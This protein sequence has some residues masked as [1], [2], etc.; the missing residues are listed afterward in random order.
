MT[1]LVWIC[2]HPYKATHFENRKSILHFIAL[3]V[4]H[5]DSSQWSHQSSHH[6]LHRLSHNRASHNRAPERTH[7]SPS[8]QR[9][10]F[11][12]TQP[13]ELWDLLCQSLS[14]RPSV[15]L[16]SHALTVQG[17]EICSA[18]HDGGTSLVSGDQIC[19][20]EFRAC[21]KKDCDKQ[22]NAIATIWKIG[23][24]ISETC[25]IGRRLLLFRHR[26][27][28]SAFHWYRIRSWTTLNDF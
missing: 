23:P 4:L 21:G 1:I 5:T 10:T 20:A 13:S 9:S 15:T 6:C 22:R 2:V 25:K 26:K 17:I 7:P 14:L 8:R 28:H 16:V 18:P 19:N 24:I 27:S 3:M 12:A 11:F